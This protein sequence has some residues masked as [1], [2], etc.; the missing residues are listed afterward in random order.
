MGTRF[1]D[2]FLRSIQDRCRALGSCGDGAA[3]RE[4]CFKRKCRFAIQDV[5]GGGSNVPAPKRFSVLSSLLMEQASY[6]NR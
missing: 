5:G 2:P 3:I 1:E 4:E 6:Q